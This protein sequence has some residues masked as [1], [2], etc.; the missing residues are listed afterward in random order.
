MNRK[1]LLS[2]SSLAIVASLALSACVAPQAAAPA[3][4][5]AAPA[6]GATA[7]PAAAAPAAED[8]NAKTLRVLY[9]QAPTILNYH[10]GQGTK[11]A[12]AARL[13]T[14]PLA[15][16]SPKAELVPILA[17]E[18]PTVANGGVSKD[19]KVVTWKLK[20]GVKWSDGSPLTADDVVFTWTY[21]ANEAT[22]CSTASTFSNIEKVEAVDA[23][24]AKLTYKASNPNVY[25]AYVG[26]Q[27]YI[28]QK[29]QF[30]KCVGEAATKDSACQAHNLKPIGTG[31]FKVR[32]FKPGD[33]VTYD[34]NEN[35]RDYPAKPAFKEVIWKGGGDAPSA[36]RAAFQTGDTDYAWNLQVEAAV[37]LQLANDPAAKATLATTGAGNVERIII[38]F[39]NP[40]PALGDKR[41]EPDQ[42]H[43]VLS[44][45]KVRQALS[46]AIDRKTM[47]TQ[48]YGPAGDATCTFLT[49]LPYQDPSQIYGKC[50]PDVDGANK[51]LDEA[52]WKKG[53]DGIREK[54][55]KKMKF[56]YNTST[57]TLRQKEQA[58]VKEAWAKLGVDVELKNV[59]ATVFFS[60]DAGNPDTFGKFWNDVQMY[61]NGSG[62]PDPTTYLCDL[63]SSEIANKANGW[64]GSNNGRYN[65][66]DYDKLCE[67]LRSEIDPAKRTTIV[68]QMNDLIVND[69]AMI[70]LVF[71]KSVSAISKQLKGT[72]MNGGWDSEMWNV[73]DWS[74]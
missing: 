58:L 41:A 47:A 69:V 29:A 27:G 44:D 9:W 56:T 13:V 46:M 68:Q 22:A 14:E 60:T 16:Y 12:D 43:P 25:E 50:E 10:Q 33:T 55:G 39:T 52:G 37:L 40:D 38:N 1:R 23:T 63:S 73:A 8:P 5:A 67:Q 36:A 35:Y 62:S 17:A 65:S 15:A 74:K 20:S 70:P 34:A 19:F 11:D 30:E 64:K 48:L 51:L 24:T 72:E 42:P 71:R 31:P 32:E 57:N 7:A 3:A 26:S 49:W 18:I 6:A 61:T 53:A 54:D 45:L 28:L 2:S 21:C 59:S 66:A 4:P